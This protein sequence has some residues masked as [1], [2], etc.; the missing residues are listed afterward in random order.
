MNMKRERER[1]RERESYCLIIVLIVGLITAS[2]AIKST[3]PG[4]SSSTLLQQSCGDSYEGLGDG[5]T[6][7]WVSTGYKSLDDNYGSSLLEIRLTGAEHDSLSISVEYYARFGSLNELIYS[8]VI[9]A[10]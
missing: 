5:A 3:S 2:I 1:E 7:E 9:Q 4:K 10:L 6:A 8:N